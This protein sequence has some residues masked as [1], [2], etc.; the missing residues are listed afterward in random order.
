MAVRKESINRITENKFARRFLNIA[1]TMMTMHMAELS[2]VNN[3]KI[4]QEL[5]RMLDLNI[6]QIKQG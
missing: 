4:L 5:A 2:S 6:P 1:V 3:R